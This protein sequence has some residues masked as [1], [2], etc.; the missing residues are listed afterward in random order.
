MPCVKPDGSLSTS[1][2]LMLEAVR[3]GS[4]AEDVANVTGMPLYR[5]RSILRELV[6][7]DYVNEEGERFT[8]TEQGAAKVKA[9]E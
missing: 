9:S 5:V 1:G 2:R 4:T 3:P 8:Q 6:D 7:A